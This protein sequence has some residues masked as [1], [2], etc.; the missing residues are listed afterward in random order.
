MNANAYSEPVLWRKTPVPHHTTW[1]SS[2]S[3]E[4]AIEFG[5][6]RML[7]RRRQ[8]LADSVPIEI[9]SRAFDLLLILL[10]SD[11]ALVTKEEL[12]NRVWLGVVVA[13][14]NLKVQIS[15]LRKA[16]GADRNLIRTEFGRGYRFI[17][18]L[19]ASAPAYA[20]RGPRRAKLR[21]CR[22]LFRQNCGQPLQG[23]FH[24]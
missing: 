15:A 7:L 13:D 4:A 2:V 14:E 8:L 17:G 9:G 23:W 11:G 12:I 6:F 1:W 3:A 19:R 22:A 24:C 20:G 16:L 18:I 21:V 5:R 10:E